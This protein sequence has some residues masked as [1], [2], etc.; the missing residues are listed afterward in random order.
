MTRVLPA[1]V[2]R[3]L[4]AAARGDLAGLRRAGMIAAG[5]ATTTLGY[6]LGAMTARRRAG[7]IST[8]TPT[9]PRADPFHELEELLVTAD[10]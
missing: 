10:G 1:G 6:M 7:A 9:L 2:A 5:A 8:H 4:A 3:N